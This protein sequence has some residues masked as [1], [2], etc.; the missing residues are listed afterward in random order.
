MHDYMADF[1][2]AGLLNL[3]GGCCG[4]TPDHIAAIAQA[5]VNKK[6]R[7]VPGIGAV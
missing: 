5:V 4:N 3:A 6:P 1:A 7:E 2:N